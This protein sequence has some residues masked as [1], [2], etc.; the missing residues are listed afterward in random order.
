MVAGAVTAVEPHDRFRAVR[1]AMETVVYLPNA[2]QVITVSDISALAF[3][4]V[5]NLLQAAG[6]F[7]DAGTWDVVGKRDRAQGKTATHRAAAV[8]L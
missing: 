2:L 7:K 6:C 1:L 3:R 8:Q 5:L 4:A